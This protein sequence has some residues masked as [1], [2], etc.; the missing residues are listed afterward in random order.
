MARETQRCRANKI[1][2]LNGGSLFYALVISVL[3]AMLT[4]SVLLAEHFSR[5]S[6]RRDIVQEELVR[7]AESGI[8]LLCASENDFTEEQDIDLFGRGKDS[9]RLQRKTWGAFD[10]CIARAHSGNQLNTRIALIGNKPDP[11]EAFALWL[12]DMDRPLSVTGQT[13]LRGKCFLPR[14]G[15]E[16]AY[17]EGS[18]YAGDQLVYGP[19]ENSERFI[20]RCNEIRLRE[21]EKLFASVA[22]D[23]DSAVSW[24]MIQSSDSLA[25]SFL[26]EP[27]IVSEQRPIR[28]SGQFISGQVCIISSVSIFVEKTA[29]LENVILVA[30]RIEIEDHTVGHFQAIARDTLMVGKETQLGYP[31]VLT[32]YTG[33]NSPEFSGLIIEERVEITGDVFAYA[34]GDD[35]RKHVLVSIGKDAQIHGCVYSSD[36]VDFKGTVLGSVTCSKFIL[37]TNSAVYE[38][39]LMNAVIDRSKCSAGFVGSLLCPQKNGMKSVVQWLE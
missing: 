27:L 34:P 12:A 5:L 21:I 33:K 11:A 2:R 9:V 1:L 28:I 24:E 15:V 19:T 7:N 36:Q 16:R 17:I 37:K 6:I 31:T 25:H 26:R 35:F 22:S 18:S 20:P 3:I 38:N 23:H 39:H 29:E 8:A 30:P 13:R 32:L 14:S 4:C 10:V